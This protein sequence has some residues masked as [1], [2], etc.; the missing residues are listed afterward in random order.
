MSTFLQFSKA[1]TGVFVRFTETK[2]TTAGSTTIYTVPASKAL[3]I[4]RLSAQVLAD[5]AGLN[6]R[7]EVYS[8]STAF[9]LVG[10][11]GTSL[12]AAGGVASSAD[13]TK[14][15]TC[16]DRF[17]AAGEIVR[18]SW[19]NTGGNTAFVKLTIEGYLINA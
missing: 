9:V 10:D 5:T 15:S 16:T 13:R 3:A 7:V 4:T 6:A 14:E 8:G 2:T 18:W 1:S 12:F 11:D 19:A 17:L